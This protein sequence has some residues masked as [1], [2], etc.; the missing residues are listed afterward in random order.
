[1]SSAFWEDRS[2]FAPDHF[3]AGDD[4]HAVFAEEAMPAFVAALAMVEAGRR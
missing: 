2:L 1:M 4:G 3:H